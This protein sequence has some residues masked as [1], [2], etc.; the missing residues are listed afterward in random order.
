LLLDTGDVPTYCWVPYDSQQ[1]SSLQNG[2]ESREG[3]EFEGKEGTGMGEAFGFG[4]P[5]DPKPATIHERPVAPN[6]PKQQEETQ[7]FGE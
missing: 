4:H 5:D 7:T 3:S 1:A 2:K 6:P